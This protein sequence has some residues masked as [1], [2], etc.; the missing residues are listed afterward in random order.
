MKK[1]ILLTCIFLTVGCATVKENAEETE[2]V[3]GNGF[4]KKLS[5]EVQDKISEMLKDSTILTMQ[6]TIDALT[7]YL[8]DY[9]TTNYMEELV[10]MAK[11]TL[12]KICKANV[13]VFP[14]PITTTS[15]SVTININMNEILGSNPLSFFG[16]KYK[17]IYDEKV[18]FEN[19]NNFCTGKEI[20]PAHLIQKEG[21]YIVI[22]EIYLGGAGEED[23]FCQGTVQFIVMK[24]K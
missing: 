1:I 9:L 12:S 14:N 5:L 3:V 10:S 22:Y 15:T 6:D 2:N 23:T 8:T 16:F 13:S 18:I 24:N 7:K 19:D 11:D 21:I 20:I 17:L 4:S